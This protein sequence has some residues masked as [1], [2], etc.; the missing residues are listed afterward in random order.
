MSVSTAVLRLAVC[1]CDIMNKAGVCGRSVYHLIIIIMDQG[2][3]KKTLRTNG[4]GWW[5][6]ILSN[7]PIYTSITSITGPSFE[8][9]K[10]LTTTGLQTAHSK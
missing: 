7:K 10:S 5:G 6:D 1:V 9:S 3:Y 2:A 4:G 8:H